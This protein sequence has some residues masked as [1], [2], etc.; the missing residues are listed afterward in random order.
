MIK[1]GKAKSIGIQNLKNL[2]YAFIDFTA[3]S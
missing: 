2:K 1:F 3:P